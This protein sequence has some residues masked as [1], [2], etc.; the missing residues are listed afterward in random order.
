MDVSTMS[1]ISITRK[2]PPIAWLSI[3]GVT[4]KSTALSGWVLFACA[5]VAMFRI[6][7]LNANHELH[8]PSLDFGICSVVATLGLSIARILHTPNDGSAQT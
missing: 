2:R 1:G 8:Y 4:P 6:M 3:P 7:A 5:L